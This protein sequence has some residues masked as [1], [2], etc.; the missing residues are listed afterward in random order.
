MIPISYS[1]PTEKSSP[2]FCAAFA[3]GCGG[4]VVD[5]AVLGEGALALFGSVKLWPMLEQARREGRDWYYGDHGYFHRSDR[6]GL[7]TGYFRVTRNR[8]QHDGVSGPADHARARALRLEVRPWRTTGS[9]ILVCPPDAVFA[10][11]MGLDAK[12]WE[13]DVMIAIRKHTD[14]P[15]RFRDR[16]SATKGRTLEQDLRDCWAMVTFMSNAAVEAVLAGIPIFALGNCAALAM[17]SSDLA[18]IE[19]PSMPEGRERWAAVLAANQWT[20]R[21]IAD[22]LCWSQIGDPEAVP[23]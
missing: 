19:A 9:H 17:G 14:R 23:A 5:N 18:K 12:A 11:L 21:E 8:F 7:E 22:G 3:W 20:L 13:M 16:L 4:R 10:D 6:F 2:R 1:V 15:V